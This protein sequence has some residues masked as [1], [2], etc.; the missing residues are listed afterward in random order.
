MVEF[1]RTFHDAICVL[2]SVVKVYII[3]AILHTLRPYLHKHVFDLKCCLDIFLPFVYTETS[4]N[5]YVHKT[6]FK[7]NTHRKFKHIY[8]YTC[9]FMYKQYRN[10]S[11]FCGT[12]IYMPQ[13]RSV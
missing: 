12:G 8:K 7:V 4:K 1:P 2:F 9:A 6:H 3:I 13:N 10:A 5:E 11:G